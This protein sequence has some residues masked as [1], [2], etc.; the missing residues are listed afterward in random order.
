M[1][2]HLLQYIFSPSVGVDIADDIYCLP[3]LAGMDTGG[4]F[5]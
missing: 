4:K 5:A 2:P 3:N 1:L